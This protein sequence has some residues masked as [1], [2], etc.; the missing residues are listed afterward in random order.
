MIN[1]HFLASW[2]SI[3]FILF[4]GRRIYWECEIV[5][6]SRELKCSSLDIWCW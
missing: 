6:L 3:F 2:E 1:I 5:K 4:R